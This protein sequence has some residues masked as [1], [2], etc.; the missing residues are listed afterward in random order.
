[1]KQILIQAYPTD[2]EVN[3]DVKDEWDREQF[4]RFAEEIKIEFTKYLT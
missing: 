2:F 3:L 1:M 4:D